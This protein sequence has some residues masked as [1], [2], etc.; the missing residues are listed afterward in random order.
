MSNKKGEAKGPFLVAI[1]GTLGSG[2]SS[3]LSILKRLGYPSI[4]VDA[5][6]R[7]LLNDDKSVKMEVKSAFGPEILSDEMDIDRAKLRSLIIN[8]SKKRRLL[9]AIIHPR[10]KKMLN[11]QLKALMEKLRDEREKSFI[12]VEVPLLFEAGWEPYFDSSIC[13]VTPKKEAVFRVIQR[14]GVDIET[15]Q[16]WYGLQWPLE[17][18]MKRAD[19]I[20]FNDGSLEQLEK[21]V[22]SLLREL[23]R[24]HLVAH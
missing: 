11:E 3:L 4:D 2:K 13:I 21:K 17:E 22:K 10:V 14:H 19:F 12:F 24:K 15:A 18:K 9:E 23:K 1:T 6:V 7:R 16:K 5:L 8:D 20:I